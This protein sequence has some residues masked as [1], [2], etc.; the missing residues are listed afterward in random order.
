MSAQDCCTVLSTLRGY[1][2]LVI[3]LADTN[4]RSVIHDSQHKHWISNLIS[5]TTNSTMDIY[6]CIKTLHLLKNCCSNLSIIHSTQ[7]EHWV[8]KLTFPHH[9]PTYGTTLRPY[10]CSRLLY[11]S[12]D[13]SRL[14]MSCY[15]TSRYQQST[16]NTQCTTQTLSFKTHIPSTIN[17]CIKTLCL[18]K[19][20]STYLS[21]LQD[22]KRLVIR[23][24]DTNS[25]S[26]IHAAQYKHW[27][28]K[29]TSLHH[30][31]TYGSLLLHTTHMRSSKQL[32]R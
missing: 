31:P 19:I 5:P 13:A 2:R 24:A 14:Q 12:V 11:S 6:Y 10:V 25:L 7:Y 23:L 9:Q 3:S 20:C 17:Y 16:D 8:S 4:S 30:Q 18:L 27:V 15:K 21:T 28:S 26:V 32:L 22:Y 1:K 29:L